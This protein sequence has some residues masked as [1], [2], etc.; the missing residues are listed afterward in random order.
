VGISYPAL[1]HFQFT[2]A[3]GEPK[4]LPIRFHPRQSK[5]FTPPEQHLR[6]VAGADGE[7]TILPPDG[8]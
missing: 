8:L 4:T 2:F 7:I 6:F 1:R 3:G 5:G